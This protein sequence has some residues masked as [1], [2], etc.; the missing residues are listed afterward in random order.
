M[1]DYMTRLL[2]AYSIKAYGPKYRSSVITGRIED[3]HPTY[4]LAVLTLAEC[5]DLIPKEGLRVPDGDKSP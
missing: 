4:R 2:N 5:G 1:S 3:N